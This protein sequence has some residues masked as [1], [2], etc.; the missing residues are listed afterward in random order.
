MK[1]ITETAGLSRAEWSKLIDNW[2][3]NE[4]DRAILKRRLLD[5]VKIEKLAEEFNLSVDGIKRIIR[6][7]KPTLE[8]HIKDKGA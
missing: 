3:F 1:K 2:I 5:E 8:N 4:K 7:H 6:K